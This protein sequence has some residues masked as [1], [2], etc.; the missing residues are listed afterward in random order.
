ML[1]NLEKGS[2]CDV[3]KDT[4]SFPGPNRVFHP[5][6]LPNVKNQTRW[7]EA[8]NT[9]LTALRLGDLLVRWKTDSVSPATVEK[10]NDPKS[11]KSFFIS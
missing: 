2:L 11:E 5:F 3:T 10:K 6:C 8:V 7:W 9:G 4:G 1:N